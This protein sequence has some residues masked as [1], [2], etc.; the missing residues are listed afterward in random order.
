MRGYKNRN[1]AAQPDGILLW[2]SK[3]S[4]IA[5][6]NWES[7]IN[8]ASITATNKLPMSTVVLPHP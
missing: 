5:E 2:Q 7:F 4:S 8:K 1:K 6:G 3:K